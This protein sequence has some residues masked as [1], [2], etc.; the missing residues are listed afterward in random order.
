MA[1]GVRTGFN[2]RSKTASTTL[3]IACRKLTAAGAVTRYRPVSRIIAGTRGMT[4]GSR[5]NREGRQ[6]RRA[7]P[8]GKNFGKSIPIFFCSRWA[9]FPDVFLVGSL[10]TSSRATALSFKKIRDQSRKEEMLD[11]VM[12]A[13]LFL[14][15]LYVLIVLA[16]EIRTSV[17]G[18]RLRRFKGKLMR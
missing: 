15:A 9:D 14:S 5:I 17:S 11:A 4:K 10:W 6:P 2:I 8:R 12:I 1:A 3:S 16:D 7:S 18:L 13:L